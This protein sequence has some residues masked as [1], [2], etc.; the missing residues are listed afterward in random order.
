VTEAAIFKQGNI[1]FVLFFKIK[2]DKVQ[3]K[4]AIYTQI[5]LLVN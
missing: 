3:R 4:N 1:W 5:G 2:S